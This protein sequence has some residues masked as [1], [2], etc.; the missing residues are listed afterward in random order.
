L[1]LIN[2]PVG[3]AGCHHAAALH[4]QTKINMRRFD[5]FGFGMLALGSRVEADA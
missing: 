1:F 3:R 5:F 4:A 2:V